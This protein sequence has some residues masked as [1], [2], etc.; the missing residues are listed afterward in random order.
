MVVTQNEKSSH[1]WSLKSSFEDCLER[2]AIH[3]ISNLKHY[4]PMDRLK[5]CEA[6]T[7]RLQIC[8]KYRGTFCQSWACTQAGRLNQTTV[9]CIGKSNFGGD[10]NCNEWSLKNNITENTY[11]RIKALWRTCSIN[12]QWWF[13]AA[14]RRCLIAS[15]TFVETYELKAFVLNIWAFV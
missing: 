3:K 6:Q 2:N 15:K 8:Q 1:L 11:K 10:G 7:T 13:R 5:F 14:D 9:C 4:K 12:S